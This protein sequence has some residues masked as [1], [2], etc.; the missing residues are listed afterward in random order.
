MF[1]MQTCKEELS[2]KEIQG[3]RRKCIVLASSLALIAVVAIV[4]GVTLGAQRSTTSNDQKKVEPT[5]EQPFEKCTSRNNATLSMRYDA[6]RAAIVS[7]LPGMETDI[8]PTLSASNAALCWLSMYDEYPLEIDEANESALDTLVQRFALATI[9]YRFHG[10]AEMIP[11]GSGFTGW[12]GASGVCQWSY[13][14][15]CSNIEAP[16]EIGRAHV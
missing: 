5:T 6:F 3:K 1:Q 8:N 11:R 12:L 10:T 13:P 4:V 2:R 9:F 14:I 16:D 7:Q 15:V